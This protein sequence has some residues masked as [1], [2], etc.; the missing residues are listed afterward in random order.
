METVTAQKDAVKAKLKM[1]AKDKREL[2]R[3]KDATDA[4]V[5]QWRGGQQRTRPL[6]AFP[7]LHRLAS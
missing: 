4:L 1:T 5:A 3:Y 7:F 2:Q 6:G